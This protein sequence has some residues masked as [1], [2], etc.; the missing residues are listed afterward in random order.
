MGLSLIARAE[1]ERLKRGALPTPHTMAY[2]ES[3]ALQAAET[4]RS[5]ARGL[6]ALAESGGDLAVA[7]RRLPDRFRHDGPPIITVTGGAGRRPSAPA[8]RCC[9]SAQPAGTAQSAGAAQT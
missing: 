9:S 2:I 7:L 5:I 4:C 3:V 1:S 6:S 8:R